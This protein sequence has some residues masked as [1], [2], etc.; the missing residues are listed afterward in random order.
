MRDRANPGEPREITG[1]ILPSGIDMA[2]SLV[3]TRGR[4]FRPQESLHASR[5]ANPPCRMASRRRLV[6]RGFTLIEI[7]VVLG[8]IALLMGIAIPTLRSARHGFPQHPRPVPAPSARGGTP[9]VPGD[10]HRPLRRRR[11]SARWLRRR[12]HQFRGGPRPVHRRHR[13]EV[14]AGRQSP[15]ALGRRRRGQ[16][17]GGGRNRGRCVGPVTG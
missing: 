13:D 5:L 14:A 15:L 16:G 2:M 17:R 12:S 9:R 7:L 4:P 11:A 8:V 3:N 6:R 1:N 10:Q